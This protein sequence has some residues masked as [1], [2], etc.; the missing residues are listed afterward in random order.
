MGA[1]H[2][3]AGPGQSILG[4]FPSGDVLPG[5]GHPDRIPGGIRNDASLSMQ[6]A[7]GAVGKNDPVI[8]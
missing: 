2:K 5:P 1:L 3:H 8:K 7:Y 6:R 4:T